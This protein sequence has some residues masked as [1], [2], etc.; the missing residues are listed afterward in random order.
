MLVTAWPIGYLLW[1]CQGCMVFLPFVSD[2]AGGAFGGVFR[3]GATAGGALVV[4][5]AGD[6]HGKIGG[7]FGTICCGWFLV[8]VPAT[9]AVAI[10]GVCII[11]VAQNPWYL[12]LVPHAIFAITLFYTGLVFMFLDTV[13]AWAAGRPY[14]VEL[15]AAV[16]GTCALERLMDPATYGDDGETLNFGMLGTDFHGYCTGASGSLHSYRDTNIAAMF[17]WLLLGI[18]C[19]MLLRRFH[20]LGVSVAPAFQPLLDEP[21]GVV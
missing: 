10:L 21:N 2:L 3:W 1:L 15:L 20:S 11:G 13:L 14:K 18:V 5:L 12:R 7:D 17:E 19:A 4:L 8:R 6:Y 16:A 9:C